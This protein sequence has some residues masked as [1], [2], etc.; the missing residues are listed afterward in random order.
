MRLLLPLVALLALLPAGSAAAAVP[1]DFFGT[2][3]SGPMWDGDVDPEAETRLMASSGVGTV[4]VAAYW[5]VAQ[6]SAG[7][8]PD[9]SGLDRVVAATAKR[10]LRVLPVIIR[11]PSWARVDPGL[12][13]S[14]PRDRG[15]YAAFA[16]AIAQRYGPSGSFWAQR[17]DLPR[18]PIRDYQIWNEPGQRFYWAPKPDLKAYVALLR[19]TRKAI[20][21]VDKNARIVLAGLNEYAWDAIADLYRAGARKNFD[22]AAV[23]PVTMQVSN[24]VEII[25][26]VRRVM[27][28][29]GDKKVP[30]GVTELSWPSAGRNGGNDFGFEVS[31]RDQARKL[32]EALPRLAALRGKYRLRWVLWETWMSFDRN[33][34]ASF[35][36]AGLRD[37]E[38]GK[39]RSKPALKEYRRAALK[40]RRR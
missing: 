5:D 24:V 29:K 21:R 30:L 9:F 39:P 28:K 27:D 10:K 20:K 40:L 37:F 3:W 7:A 16:A 35:D 11:A 1:S 23:H 19:T 2:S 12:E 14:P 13:W 36:F 34:D 8:P 22:I 26:R 33:R 17:T 4:R 31:E 25:R 32:K 15:Q 6:P 38:G 18:I